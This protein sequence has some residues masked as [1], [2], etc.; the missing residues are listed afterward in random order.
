METFNRP[1]V[2]KLR[3]E[4]EAAML[5]GSMQELSQKLGVEFDLGNCKFSE[6]EA[7]FQ[8]KARIAGAKTK[9]EEHLEMM[10][11]L[12]NIDASKTARFEGKEIRLVGYHSSRPKWSWEIEYAKTGKRVLIATGTAERLFANSRGANDEK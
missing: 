8:F 6:T 4:L 7:T 9:E 10:A 1:T 5:D 3:T 12:H 2:K 11:E